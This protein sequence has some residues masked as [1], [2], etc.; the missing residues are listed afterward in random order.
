VAELCNC[1]TA[2]IPWSGALAWSASSDKENEDI[3]TKQENFLDEADPSQ[4]FG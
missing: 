3:L 2:G 4:G 1:P